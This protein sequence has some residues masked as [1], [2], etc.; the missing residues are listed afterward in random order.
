MTYTERL[1]RNTLLYVPGKQSPA[2]RPAAETRGNSRPSRRPKG[3]TRSGRG[4]ANTKP[5]AQHS[6]DSPDWG[7][8]A[9][10]KMLALRV[11]KPAA[12]QRANG[13]AI[14]LDY[15]SSAYWQSHWA[16]LAED[17]LFTVS[18]T[19]PAAFLDG[20]PG[21][22]VLELK[23]RL[24][25]Y[26][27]AG[28]AAMPGHGFSGTGFINPA[29][30]DGGDMVQQCWRLFVDDYLKNRM[31]SGVWVGFN[32]E[33]LSSLQN[34]AD[35][36]TPLHPLSV[37][38]P[39]L[40]AL[41]T[42]IPS[43]RARYLVHPKRM[44]AVIKKKIARHESGTKERR[45]LRKQLAKLRARK[46]DAPVSGDQPPHASYVTILWAR[47]MRLRADQYDRLRA[48]LVDAA[49]DPKALFHRCALLHSSATL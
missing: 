27:R 29:G 6:A 35:M 36:E 42:I 9:E 1:D 14:S 4:K 49:R 2:R 18:S 26:G 47:D 28:V 8:P 24:A 41:S 7:T 33:T 20:K 34:L 12:P 45:A 19:R 44:E 37:C 5:S 13:C 22:N 11:L 30:L 3:E 25:A 31:I 10:M 23:H 32:I 48:F 38:D 40:A 17:D 39:Q 16:S 46:T 15:S 43:R 21:R